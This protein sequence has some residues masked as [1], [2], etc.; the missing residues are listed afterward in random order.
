MVKAQSVSEARRKA[1]L[2]NNKYLKKYGALLWSSA[3]LT[4]YQHGGYAELKDNYENMPFKYQSLLLD[5]YR[6]VNTEKELSMS[7]A[8]SRPYMDKKDGKEYIDGLI[9]RLEGRD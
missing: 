6:Y 7:Q 2:Q 8:A 4:A 1:A 3:L 5:A 9:R